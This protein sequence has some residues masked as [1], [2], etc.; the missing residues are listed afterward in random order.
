MLNYGQKQE[1]KVAETLQNR[2]KLKNVIRTDDMEMC[3]NFKGKR[4][5]VRHQ[6]KYGD[7]RAESEMFGVLYF[8][9]KTDSSAVRTGNLFL[10]TFSDDGSRTGNTTFG[11]M[12]KPAPDCQITHFLFNLKGRESKSVI[13]RYKDLHEWFKENR[14]RFPEVKMVYDQ[15]QSNRSRGVIVPIASMVSE[16]QSCHIID[17]S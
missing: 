13:V 16:I 11:W 5:I 4:E 1:I 2:F 8:E 3:K 9:L 10:E 15:K 6:H 7:I 17:L 14:Y 12:T